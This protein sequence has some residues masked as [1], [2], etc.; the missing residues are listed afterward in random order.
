MKLV[1]EESAYSEII[2]E[3]CSGEKLRLH[4][5]RGMNNSLSQGNLRERWRG[6]DVQ[7]RR[8]SQ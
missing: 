7:G 8:K 5:K 2:Q 1:V 3:A 6:S 4:F